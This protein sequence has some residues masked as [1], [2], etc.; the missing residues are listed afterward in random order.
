MPR[1]SLWNALRPIASWMI[2]AAVVSSFSFQSTAADNGLLSANATNEAIAAYISS[3]LTYLSSDELAGRGVGSEGI[4][5]AGEF[6]ATRFADLGLKTDA[7]DGTPFQNFSI[8]GQFKIGAAE[9]NFL[10]ASSEKLGGQ[11]KLEIGQDFNSMTLGSNGAFSGEVA[12]AG[13]GISAED[14]QY[15]DFAGWDAKGKVVIVIRKEPQQSDANSRFNGTQN[16][17]YAFFGTKVLNAALH[18]AAALILVNDAGTV[19][20]AKALVERELEAAEKE[21]SELQKQS[22]ANSNDAQIAA[23]LKGAVAQRDSLK[24]KLDAGK[25]DTLLTVNEGGSVAGNNRVPTVFASRAA[26]DK[27]L[28]A[29]LSKSLEQLE[30]EID[31]TGKPQSAMLSGVSIQGET[32]TVRS[33]TPVRN[34]IGVLPGS[35]SLAEEFVVVGAHYDHVGMGGMGSLAPGTIAV[36]NGADDNGSGTT[37]MMEIARQCASRKSENRRTLIFMAF[38]A[39]ESGLL[40]SVHYVNNPRWPLEKTVAM[41]NLDMVGRLFNNELTVYGT[42]TAKSFDAQIDRLGSAHRF[43]VV[44]VPQGRG[45]SDHQSFYDKDIPVFHFFTGLHNEYH[46]PSDDFPLIN[47]EGMVRISRLASELVGELAEA[48][49][50]PELVKIQGSA[51]PRTQAAARPTRALLGVRLPAD[52]NALSTIEAVT[53]GGVADKAGIKSGDQVVSINETKVASAG[54]LRSALAKL[55]TDSKVKVVLKRGEEEVTLEINLSE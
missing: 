9:K 14:L 39:E 29:G 28:Q 13:Y 20:A 31:S 53:T 52:Q 55:K 42:G 47:V 1:N 26:V 5:K 33:K 11:W 41:V 8:P 44:K 16:T 7:F 38:S 46:R 3:D 23:K 15:D 21:V 17:P 30:K 19:A 4:T 37:T 32:E 10:T 24:L 27:L 34:V 40:G 35:G 51:A 6:I 54:E 2:G 36:H 22:E 48:S 45:A 50:K 18:N 49:E 25:F 43:K 12:F